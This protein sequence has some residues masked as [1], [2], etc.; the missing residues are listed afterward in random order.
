M[1]TY[2]TCKKKKIS[3]ENGLLVPF[4]YLINYFY[5]VS[6]KIFTFD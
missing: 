5:M 2:D 3:I 4:S 1:N 6:K